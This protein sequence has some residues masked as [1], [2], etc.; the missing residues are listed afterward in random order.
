MNE[1]GNFVQIL[2]KCHWLNLRIQK[3]RHV[4]LGLTQGCVAMLDGDSSGLEACDL[5]GWAV[6]VEFAVAL[7]DG[8]EVLVFITVGKLH[9]P[10]MT[11]SCA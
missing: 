2:L 9:A 7:P 11:G 10:L 8:A 4:L 1:S 5:M 6:S 3:Q